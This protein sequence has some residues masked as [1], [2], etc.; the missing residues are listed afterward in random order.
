[1]KVN[2]TVKL[3]MTEKEREA[4][5]TVFR[6]LYDLEWDDERAVANELDYDDLIPMRNALATLYELGGRDME[7][8]K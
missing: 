3:E 8:L 7:D 2:K 6:M 4:V 1:M 5:K